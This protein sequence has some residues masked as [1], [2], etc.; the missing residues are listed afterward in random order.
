MSVVVFVGL[1]EGIRGRNWFRS[2]FGERLVAVRVRLVL[3]QFWVAKI[4]RFWILV[5]VAWA[6]FMLWDRVVVEIIS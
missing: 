3:A 1:I 4:S 6:E 2:R 5:G